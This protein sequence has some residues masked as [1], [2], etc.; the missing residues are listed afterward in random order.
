MININ[1]IELTKIK[2]NITDSDEW[3]FPHTPW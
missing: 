3:N 1:G 2:G